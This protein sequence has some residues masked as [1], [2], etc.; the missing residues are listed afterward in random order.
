MFLMGS[1]EYAAQASNNPRFV[2]RG[3]LG[4]VP[5][6]TV[7]DGVG[8]PK[9]VIGNP[10][11]Y[12]SVTTQSAH[13]DAAVNLVV[14]MTTSKQYIA[15]LIQA[16]QVPAVKGVEN[17]LASSRNAEFATFTY[18]LVADTPSFTQSWDQALSPSVAGEL[19]TNLQK[20]FLSD[21]SP[22]R[23]VSLMEKAK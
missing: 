14:G 12:F 6:P 17:Q 4:W 5:F 16:G 19:L 3:Q 7:S 21:I 15:E 18:R 13:R 23:F 10:N 22:E 11:N 8:D 2:S 20:L 9:N 1:W